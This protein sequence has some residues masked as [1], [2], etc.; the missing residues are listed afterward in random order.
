MFKNLIISLGY[1]FAIFLI[2]TFLVTILHY[3]SFFHSKVIS[4]CKLFIPIIS[5]FIASYN[6]G[7]H[8][9]E[10]GY[11]E[12]IKIGGTIISVFFVMIF[13][14]DQFSVK[15]L[16]YYFILLLTAILSS[17]MGINRKKI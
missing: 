5:M 12:G 11:L 4:I 15:S 17:M 8:S 16:L 6:L 7:K 9:K 3:F 10:K 1:F 2:T 13:L 14:L